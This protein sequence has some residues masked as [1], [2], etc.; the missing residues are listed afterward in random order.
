MHQAGSPG[1]QDQGLFDRPVAGSEELLVEV[2]ERHHV[3]PVN[4]VQ[5][6]FG[7][8]HHPL[9]ESIDLR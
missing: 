6:R 5:H 9:V 4:P 8:D 1:Q 7:A 2:E 3:G